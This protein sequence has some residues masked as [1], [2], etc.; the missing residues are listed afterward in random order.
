MIL[1]TKAIA[2]MRGKNVKKHVVRKMTDE[3]EKAFDEAFKQMDA[4]FT[5]MDK[6]FDAL[7]KL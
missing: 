3:E 5:S 7:R 1:I 6:A 2:F 4:A